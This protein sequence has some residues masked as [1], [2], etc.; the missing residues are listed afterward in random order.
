[1]RK[2]NYFFACFMIIFG[3][4]MNAQT[5]KITYSDS[6][7]DAGF[8]LMNQKADGVEIIYSIKELSITENEYKGE[9]MHKIEIPGIFLFN[10][11]GQPDLPGGGRYVA[12]PNGASPEL[13]IIDYRTEIIKDVNVIPAPRLPRDIEE[14]VINFNKDEKVYTK[15]AFYPENPIQ[16]SKPT[17]LRGVDV[18]MLG[19]TPFQYN[20]V[21]KELIVYHDIKVEINY[22]SNGAVLGDSRLRNQWWDPILNDAL[23]NYSALPEIDYSKRDKSKETGEFEYIIIVP[24]NTDFINYANQIKEFRRKQGISTGVFTTTE[25]GGNTSAA[26]EAFINNAY[27][28]WD[29]APVAV[30]LM[31]DYGS[32]GNT[33]TSPLYGDGYVGSNYCISD[34]FYADV[35]GD[36][37][38]DITF[39]RMTA[40]NATHLETMV[41]KFINYE[42]NPPVDPYFYSHAVTALGWQDDR[43][44]QICSEVVGGFW[45]D[46]GKTTVRINALG[47]PASNYNTG[48]WST[49]TYANTTAV[50][51]T[52]GPSGLGYIPNTPQEIGGFTGGNA[53]MVNNAINAGTFMFQHR[54]HGGTDGWGEPAYYTSNI[55]GLTNVDNKLPYVWS[56][57]CLTGKFN[58]SGEVFAERFHRYTYNGQ[59]S[60]ALGILAATESSYSFVNDIYVWGAYDNMWPEFMP[61]EVQNPESRFIYPAF[62]NVAG[63]NYLEQ[64]SWPT[65]IMDAKP[66]TYYL[67]HHH[68]DAFLNV[69]SEVPQDLSVTSQDVHIFGSTTYD[70]TVDDGAVIA[71]TY[72]DDVNDETVIVAT[73]I[74]D[75]G[76]ASLDMTNCPPVGTNMLLTLT[77][78]NFFRF[79]KNVLVIAPDGPYV[80]ADDFLINDG[81]NNSAEYAETFNMDITLKNVGS[82]PSSSVT[83]TLTTSDAYVSSLTNATSVSYPNIDPNASAT[84]SGSFTFVLANN[85]PDQHTVMCDLAITDNST[86]EIYNS[87]ISFK[88]NAPILTV[89]NLSINDAGGNADGILDPGETA[90]IL[91]QTTNTGH[92]DVSNVIGQI[93]TTSPYLILNTMSTSPVSLLEGEAGVFSFNVMASAAAEEGTLAD[94][95]FSITGGAENQYSG[96]N[97]FDIVIGFVP[98]YC[99]ASGGCDEYISRVQFGTIDNSSSCDGYHDYTAISSEVDMGSSYPITVTVGTPYSSD[100]LAA[101][102]DWNY[103]GDFTDAGESFPLTW[104]SPNATGNIMVPEGI[105]PRNLTMRIRLTYNST[106][107]P[108]GTTT[109]GEAEDYTLTVLPGITQGGTL[110]ATNSMVCIGSSTG[111][112]TLS[113]NSGTVTDWEKRLNGGA[114]TSIGNTATTYSETTAEAGTW[115]YRVAVDAG[116]AYSTVVSIVVNP[117]TVSGSVSGGSTVCEGENTGTLTLSGHIGNVQR[118]QKQLNGGTWSN[119]TNTQSTYSEIPSADGTWSYRAVVKSGVCSEFNSEI[120]D[121]IVNPVAVSGTASVNDNTVCTG[122]TVDL[123]LT[124]YVGDIQWQISQNG[125]DWDNITDAINNT[126][127]SGSLTA[128]SWFRAVVSLGDCGDDVSN[129]IAVT[130]SENPVSGFTYVPNNQ[131]I[132]FTN[133][134]SNAS[135]YSWDFGDSNTST[136]TNPVHTYA[137]AGNYTVTLTAVNGVCPNDEF[138]QV[139][140]V[141]YVGIVD[142]EANIQINPNP[143]NGK[144]TIHTGRYDVSSLSIFTVN[145]QKIVETVPNAREFE[146]DLSNMPKGIY[147]I[148]IISDEM[149]INKK[150]IIK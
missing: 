78:Q 70:V 6:W 77:K 86:K 83:A 85:V 121:V 25:I 90:D 18:V 113:N 55:S 20:P 10:D 11:E 146:M 88:V 127:T 31:A 4:A 136:Q 144:F 41:S 82:D 119:I 139:L 67:F 120:T 1:M 96:N 73:D 5:Q 125:T 43:W 2:L 76:V 124:S 38:P 15:N 130:I 111:T 19:I 57:N 89:G 145:G 69:Y 22:K 137:A 128:N 34:N 115:E 47:S 80:V 39:A 3:F 149:K 129:T 49:T 108:C 26:I 35:T 62:A 8:N 48:P 131:T 147:F 93:S 53:T 91:I 33:I 101:Y 148:E 107:A 138:E 79:T 106:P 16:I 46:M 54:D 123:T 45:T 105:T 122:S 44:F 58:E 50:M 110:S 81:D 84:S 17:K 112:I 117:S 28:T 68:G 13:K 27:N 24:D 52:F 98:E 87:H 126:Y 114:W 92:A 142:L 36:D 104:A 72:F 42:S 63:K 56:V 97:D 74:A 118:W 99:E 51:N 66:V 141:T 61:G 32:T 100:A 12:I 133:T 14:F 95:L 9:R 102:V 30:L 7:G 134:S 143:S 23:L 29:P 150:L 60:G 59:N 103:D 94:L 135:G 37:L 21:T 140:N 109:Y 132:T 65:N 64:S 71:L 40:Q 116:A 75:G